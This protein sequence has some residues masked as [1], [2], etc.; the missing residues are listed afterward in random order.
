MKA[1]SYF[2]MTPALI[3]LFCSAVWGAKSFQEYQQELLKSANT[4]LLKKRL[5]RDFFPDKGPL[6]ISGQVGP[7]IPEALAPLPDF[8]VNLDPFTATYPQT[9]PRVIILP[10]K[11]SV[12]VWE[13]TRNGHFDIY[14]QKYDSSGVAVGANVKINPGPDQS[15]QFLPDI[16]IDQN[17][18]L[19]I[20]WVDYGSLDIIFKRFDSTL[21]ALAPSTKVNTGPANT[22]WKP[23]VAVAPN[24]SFIVVWEDIRAGFN[25]YGQFYDP[26]GAPIGSNFKINSDVG[27]LPHF[28][29]RVE[30]DGDGNLVVGWEDYRN[31]DGDIYFQRYDASGAPVDTNILV[32]PD[33]SNEDQYLPDLDRSFDGRIA[34]T[35]VDTRN[36]QPDIYVQRVSAGGALQ[37]GA[38]KVNTDA[39]TNEQWDP[40]V[41]A[42]SLF[43]FVI[44]WADY[45]STPAIY[46][47]SYDSLGNTVGI[48]IPISTLN[49]LQERNSPGIDRHRAGNYFI[50]WQDHRA[51][52]F[53]I[54]G[55]RVNAS[56]VMTGVNFKLNDDLLG[57][58]QKN[59][60][61]ATIPN[62][63]FYIAWEDYRSGNADVYLRAFDRLGNPLITDT[64]VN[65][66]VSL[67]DQTFPDI[68]ADESGNLLVTWLDLSSGSRIMGQ[69]Y[70]GALLPNGA[71]VQI[72]DGAGSI[73]HQR[74]ACAATGEGKFL[75]VWSDNRN[76]LV[77]MNIYGQLFSS[78]GTLSGTNFKV[79]DDVSSL[80]HLN[81]RVGAD[82]N[83]FFAAAWQDS[84][85][86]QSRIYLRSYDGSGT[87]QGASFPVESD[88]AGTV[89]IL[90]DISVTPQASGV[91]IWLEQRGYGSY[92]LAQRYSDAGT[93][94]GANLTIADPLTGLVNNP[95]VAVDKNDAFFATWEDKRN[96]DWDV[97]GQFYYASNDSAGEDVKV[98]AD[99]GSNLQLSPDVA[100]ARDEA[101]LAWA[102]NRNPNSGLDIF[103]KLI[104]YQG[105]DVKQPKSG[106]SQLPQD[107]GL[108]QNYP[109]PFNAVTHIQFALPKESG[110]EIVVYDLLGRKVKTFDLGRLTAGYKLITW[111]GRNDRGDVVASGVYFYR[112]K[113]DSFSDVRKMTLLK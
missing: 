49:A 32:S 3:L 80:D 28:A 94:L 53:D 91:V 78:P 86:G 61:I 107:F 76:V 57:A 34:I 112:I 18:N 9:N 96:G 27:L 77:T 46:T 33:V 23:A 30:Y 31:G 54:Y 16:G 113:T 47:Q 21:A 109:N 14:A 97:Y 29:P 74:P 50:A 10:S 85:S 6:S 8:K 79:N 13:E 102:D 59:P 1:K 43:R 26:S 56:D 72:S 44:S 7:H 71:N 4:E 98:N 60:A 73:V 19:V 84:R 64:K 40:A 25:A 42:D 90:P 45:R 48:N 108:S 66:D 89:Q 92:V 51:N 15:D 111:D 55:Q 63:S 83:N 52:N 81:P 39:G 41:G 104:S 70:D 103:A 37:G 100:L 75:T 68:C 67:T 99:A 58:F 11:S 93:P 22:A 24:G 36:G 17:G 101:Y 65:S 88:S 82:S 69:F 62:G 87:P 2:S 35:Y 38:V 20:V 5:A 12:A 110:V 105:V 106:I 95:R